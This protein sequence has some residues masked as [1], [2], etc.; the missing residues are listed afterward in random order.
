MPEP[1]KPSF[2]S[3]GVRGIFG[4]GTKNLDRDELFGEGKASSSVAQVTQGDA[5]KGLTVGFC[6]NSNVTKILLQKSSEFL[7]QNS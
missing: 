7:E 4:G 3:A 6:K 1:P 2:F 5:L